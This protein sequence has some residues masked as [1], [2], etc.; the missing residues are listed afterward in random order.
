MRPG[1]T[2]ATFDLRCVN[3][4]S[5]EVLGESRNVAL[6]GTKLTDHFADFAVHLYRIP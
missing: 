1:T 5:A 4:G 2:D 3:G 6:Q